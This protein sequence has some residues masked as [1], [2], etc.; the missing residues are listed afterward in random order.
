LRLTGRTNFRQCGGILQEKGLRKRQGS[1]RRGLRLEGSGISYGL[2]LC[3]CRGSFPGNVS[4]HKKRSTLILNPKGLRLSEGIIM[5][6][7]VINAPSTKKN[8]E[9]KR[10]PRHALH[11]E[12]EP[13]LLRLG[14]FMSEWTGG[15][16]HD[17][18]MMEDSFT[19]KRASSSETRPTWAERR[20]SRKRR[21]GR[22]T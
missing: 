17:P 21:P 16:V 6:A 20:R 11:E 3:F 12:W 8:R 22:R 2:T 5:D 14:R 4:A 7:T 15:N 19:V 13:V 9:K 10:D 18:K 1:Q